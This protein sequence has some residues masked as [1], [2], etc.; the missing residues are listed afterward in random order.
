MAHPHTPTAPTYDVEKLKSDIIAF[1]AEN[2][3]AMLVTSGKDGY[4]MAR[5]MG[6]LNE[7][8]TI[9][10]TTVNSSLKIK[11]M[12]DNDKVTVL[13]KEP[14]EHN[15]QKMRFVTL[16]GTIEIFEDMETVVPIRN[17]YAE[18]YNMATMPAGDHTRVVMK[19]TPLYL[20]AEGFGIAPPP[21]L[22]SL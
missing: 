10:F 9:W 19:F 8:L 1:I 2:R 20:R 12:Q 6:Y 3:L 21:I 15:H 7:G 17:R 16:K 4:P 14:Y 13:W 5:M 22:R 11:Q 18:K